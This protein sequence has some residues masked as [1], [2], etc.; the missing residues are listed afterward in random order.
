[1]FHARHRA[2][3]F[4]TKLDRLTRSVPDARD[5]VGEPTGSGVRLKIGGSVHDPTDLIGRLLF[6]V[7]SMIAEFEANLALARTREGLAVAEENGGKKPMPKPTQEAHMVDLWR[8][9]DHATL[10][11]ADLFSVSRAPLCRAI[12][13]RHSG[14]SAC[15]IAVTELR[16][17]ALRSTPTK[18]VE[19]QYRERT[20]PDVDC[21]HGL[22]YR[23]GGTLQCGLR[24]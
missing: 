1:M 8:N 5:I 2:S 21:G 4:V 15:Q 9:G 17:L 20:L 22:R 12:Q 13:R 23:P 19:R 7:L 10:E 14:R 24:R 6:T 16:H 3:Q 11:L 18:A